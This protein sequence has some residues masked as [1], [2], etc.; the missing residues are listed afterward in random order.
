MEGI[1]Q[2]IVSVIYKLWNFDITLITCYSALYQLLVTAQTSHRIHPI[3]MLRC[4]AAR[5]FQCETSVR[6]R[7]DMNHYNHIQLPDQE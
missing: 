1:Q 4:L 6:D 5:W 7:T 2:K 3:W